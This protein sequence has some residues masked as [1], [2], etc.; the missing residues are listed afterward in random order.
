[1]KIMDTHTLQQLSQCSLDLGREAVINQTNVLKYFKNSNDG[2]VW[3]F[4]ANLS[5]GQYRLELRNTR[6]AWRPEP[7]IAIGHG[8]DQGQGQD[9]EGTG[10]DL[11]VTDQGYE[12][13][14]QR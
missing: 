13:D 14:L 3:A 4:E 10:P 9:N 5:E 6:Q 2:K 11:D 7:D 8:P 12:T 1:M